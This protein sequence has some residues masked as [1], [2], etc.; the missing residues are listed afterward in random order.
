MKSDTNK[1]KFFEKIKKWWL[2]RR[3]MMVTF[4]YNIFKTFFLVGG[5]GFDMT[6]EAFVLLVDWDLTE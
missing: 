3:K 1:T 4:S 6:L 2:Q 5:G